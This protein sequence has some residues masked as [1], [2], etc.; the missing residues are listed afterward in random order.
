MTQA[1]AHNSGD[2]WL[3]VDHCSMPSNCNLFHE[4]NFQN[5][6]IFL[7]KRWGNE[8]RKHQI[9]PA[10][11]STA[12]KTLKFLSQVLTGISTVIS[13]QV[14]QCLIFLRFQNKKNR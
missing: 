9:S 6:W 1:L 14:K 7:Y 3:S 12:Q 13:F 2:L 8:S 4:E 10:K 5:L 11:I